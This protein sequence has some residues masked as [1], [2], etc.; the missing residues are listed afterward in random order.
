MVG[1][2]HNPSE[3]ELLQSCGAI[4][5]YKP[6]IYM[7]GEYLHMNNIIMVSTFMNNDIF[8][9]ISFFL[10]LQLRLCFCLYL[11]TL[12]WHVLSFK[13]EQYWSRV[14]VTLPTVT[15]EMEHVGHPAWS[16]VLSCFL[17]RHRH[18]AKHTRLHQWNCTPFLPRSYLI[19]LIISASARI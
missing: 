2:K 19:V 10:F 17:T 16:C 18:R 4:N 9:A 1:T 6:I 12:I 15:W 14:L 11:L 13:C 5:V 7:W 8:K 3:S